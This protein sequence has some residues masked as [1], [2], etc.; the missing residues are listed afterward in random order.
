MPDNKG[1]VHIADIHDLTDA[2][3]TTET[4]PVGA[5]PAIAPPYAKETTLL[6]V[7]DVTRGKVSVIIPHAK[8]EALG[9]TINSV[10]AQDY[11][12]ELLEVIVVGQLGEAFRREWPKVI[13]IDTGKPVTPGRARNLGAAQSSGEVLIF[14]DDD[15]EAQANWIRE[16]LKELDC[17]NVGVVGGI[18][19]GKSSGFIARAVD[20]ANFGFC[21]GGSREERPVCSASLA[22]RKELF[23]KVGGFDE[24]MRAHEDI[25]LCHRVDLAG[26]TAVYQPQ[27]KILHNHGRTHTGSMLNYMYFGGRAAGLETERKYKELSKFYRR[28]LWFRNP[29]LYA[30]AALPFA[31]GA[32]GKTIIHNFREH[33]VVLLLSPA[34]F[35]AKLGCHVGIL[36]SLASRWISSSWR[37]YGVL[38]NA[39]RLFEYSFLKS[40]FRTPRILT[41]SVTSQCNAKCGHCFFWQDLNKPDDLSFEEI[42]ELSIS[43]GKL[44]KLLI[45][46]GEPFL[47]RD[48]PEICGLFFRNNDLTMVSI[49]TNGLLPDRIEKQVRRL[50][51]IADGRTV[52]ISFSLDGLEDVHDDLRGVPGNFAKVVESYEA[53]HSLQD[54]Y[55]NLSLRV[56]SVVMN[57]TIDSIFGLI[58]RVPKLF[59]QINTPALTLLRGGPMDTSLLLPPIREMAK[60]FAYKSRNIPG[61]QP[62]IWRAADWITFNLSL[63]TLREDTQVVPCEAGRILGVV[64]A[65]GTVKHCELLPPI[66]NLRES[67]FNSIWNSKKAK[68]E[69]KKIVEKQC[70]CTHECN[71]FPS[72]LAHPIKGAT[73]LVKAA[74]ATDK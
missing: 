46:G 22:I 17:S 44:D 53:L 60:L 49:P 24:R 71:L 68:Q 36:H 63:Q 73:A 41:L 65:N 11:P 58:D 6:P 20:F 9:N 40:L 37:R 56:N 14:L 42:Q 26:F 8:R 38:Q 25:D 45:T 62:L 35:L 70:R 31:L 55:A 54:E 7:A 15:C 47:H 50:L 13:T 74:V 4:G 34:I 67:D 28:L 23:D 72:A 2:D 16:N 3:I 39:R 5:V 32:T 12:E 48:L 43:L 59:P 64:E 27:V 66:G 21:Q 51:V 1:F 69:R 10:I 61:K 33:R 18:V 19:E 30:I 29:F 52:N 57:R